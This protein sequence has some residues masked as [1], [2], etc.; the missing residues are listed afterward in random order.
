VTGVKVETVDFIRKLV[1][2]NF[3]DKCSQK[4]KEFIEPSIQL[5]IQSL[6]MV[7]LADWV[8]TESDITQIVMKH[9]G[10]FKGT[11]IFISLGKDVDKFSNMVDIE[12]F[13]KIKQGWSFKKKIDY[14]HSNG[15]LQENTYQLLD[16]AREIRNKIHEMFGFSEPDYVLF[17]LAHVVSYLIWTAICEQNTYSDSFRA[18]AEQLA[19]QWLEKNNV[20][21]T[22]MSTQR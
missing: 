18:N 10:V 1:E 17:H 12:A 2:Q 7:P 21:G 9:K 20:S 3:C 8:Q 22:S 14:L 16:N 15:I 6:L 5:R 19:K 13:K 11:A 4:Y